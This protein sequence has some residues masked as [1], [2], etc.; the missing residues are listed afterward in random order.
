MVHTSPLLGVTP[1]TRKRVRGYKPPAWNGPQVS[2]SG[3][4]DP[5]D[6]IEVTPWDQKMTPQDPPRS[7]PEH[8]P[9]SAPEVLRSCGL[10]PKLGS[11]DPP[12]RSIRTDP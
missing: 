7:T 11:Q 9:Q 3:H 6:L 5:L 12:P 1:L 2:R 10:T 8:P 4:P